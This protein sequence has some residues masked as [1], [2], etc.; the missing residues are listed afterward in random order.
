MHFWFFADYVFR[1]GICE[2]QWRLSQLDGVCAMTRAILFM[3]IDRKQ[4][5]TYV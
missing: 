2:N 5:T 4:N 3:T 1:I